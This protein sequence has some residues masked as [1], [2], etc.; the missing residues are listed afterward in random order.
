MGIEAVILDLD[1]TLVV[2]QASASAA[3]LAACTLASDKYGVEADKLHQ[4]VRQKARELWHASPARA[5]CVSIGISS[6]EGLWAGFQGDDPNLN[7]LRKWAPGYRRESWLRALA[8]HGINEL[9]FAERLV[10]TFRREPRRLHIV[11]PDVERVLQQLRKTYQL[12][13]LTNGA[14]DLQREKLRGA[15]LETYFDVIVISGDIG[16]GKPDPRVFA[17]VLDELAIL[18]D[19][20]VM[21]G[22]SLNRDILGAR[23]AGL[24]GV[25]I[26]RDMRKRDGSIT[27]D[28]EIRSMSEL[29]ECLGRFE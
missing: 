21:V 8:E 6:W 5:Y 27:P 20:A 14:P 17:A 23:Q 16:V 26:N 11:F 10:E 13:L 24:K 25:W 29:C 18:P 12:A 28:C 15:G 1:D 7:I 9:S 4:M 19:M 22:D 2:E 3:F